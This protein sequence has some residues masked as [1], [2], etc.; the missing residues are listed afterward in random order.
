MVDTAYGT[1]PAAESKGE[2]HLHINE[3]FAEESYVD[4][5]IEKINSAGEDR[6]VYVHATHAGT[7]EALA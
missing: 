1:E 7:A 5:L 4:W 3:F 2:L 6:E